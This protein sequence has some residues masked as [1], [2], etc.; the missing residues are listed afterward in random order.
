[1]TEKSFHT[2][3]KDTVLNILNKDEFTEDDQ[4]RLRACKKLLK[5]LQ[6][7]EDAIEILKIKESKKIE[8]V[9]IVMKTVQESGALEG[10]SKG[11]IDLLTKKFN[12]PKS[13]KS[14]IK[15]ENKQCDNITLS[16]NE[17]FEIEHVINYLKCLDENSWKTFKS[18]VDQYFIKK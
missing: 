14:E 10:L 4:K 5:K 3:I 2:Q 9:T 16:K 1:M 11:L 15:N 18:T 17:E 13:T 6:Q 8:R 7:D 12:E